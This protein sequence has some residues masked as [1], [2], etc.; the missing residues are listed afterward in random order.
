MTFHDFNSSFIE[1]SLGNFMTELDLM[2]IVLVILWSL[3]LGFNIA[4]TY[5]MTH[6]G[7][8]LFLY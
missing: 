6:R 4:F 3:I 5:R 1:Q 7:K 2:Y 8:T